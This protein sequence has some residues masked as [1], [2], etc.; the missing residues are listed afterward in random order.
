MSSRP[1]TRLALPLAALLLVS[2]EDAQGPEPDQVLAD[3][4]AQVAGSLVAGDLVAMQGQGVPGF[5]V[6]GMLFPPMWSGMPRC[7]GATP[8]APATHEGLLHERTITFFDGSGAEQAAYDSLTTAAIRFQVSVTG[9]IERFDWSAELE[10]EH[11][12]TLSGL[13]GTETQATWNG[14]GTGR[15]IRSATR[16]GMVRT[17]LVETTSVVD[18]VVV[19]RGT[20]TYWPLAGSITQTHR[21]TRETVQGTVSVVRT[22]VI[23]FDGTRYAQLTIGDRTYAIDLARRGLPMPERLRRRAGTQG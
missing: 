20:A 3:E 15:M 16:D 4:V 1:F 23:S 5:G 22:A 7:G 13:V 6:I 12:L 9:S 11:D 18:D 19:P 10:R 2:C 17:S 21:V 8:C 14:S